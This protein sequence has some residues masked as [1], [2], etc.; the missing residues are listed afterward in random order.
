M[1]TAYS[2]LT[3]PMSCHSL[4]SGLHGTGKISGLAKAVP[5][6]KGKRN[7]MKT[8]KIKKPRIKTKYQPLKIPNKIWQTMK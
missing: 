5:R 4:Q 6:N 1:A 7:K 2:K 3:D 8:P